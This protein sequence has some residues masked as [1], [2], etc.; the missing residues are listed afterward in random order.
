MPPDASDPEA[1]DLVRRRLLL[2]GAKY[3]APAVTISLTLEGTAY[4][5]ASCGPGSCKPATCKP[6]GFCKPNGFCKPDR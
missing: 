4:A 6:A 5:Q 3:V 2:A 1:V